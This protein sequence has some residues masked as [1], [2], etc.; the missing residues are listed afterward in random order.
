MTVDTDKTGE[1]RQYPIRSQFHV[2]TELRNKSAEPANVSLANRATASLC[3]IFVSKK[4]EQDKR[5]SRHEHAPT[6]QPR[7]PDQITTDTFSV[8]KTNRRNA[9]TFRIFPQKTTQISMQS[10]SFL[11]PPFR[12]Q[13]FARESCICALQLEAF[14][15]A[16]T[17]IKQHA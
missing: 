9:A 8:R 13:E 7:F 16:Y 3:A 10:F 4:A 2:N 5:E 6:G 17:R 1:S 11:R 14:Q 12:T 15:Q